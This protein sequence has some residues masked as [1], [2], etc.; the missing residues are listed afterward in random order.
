MPF[1]IFDNQSGFLHFAKYGCDVRRL[2]ELNSGHIPS[3]PEGDDDD[4]DNDDD[5]DDKGRRQR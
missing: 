2:I 4:D 1:L 5:D 3:S